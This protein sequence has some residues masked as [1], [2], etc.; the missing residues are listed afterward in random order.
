MR[1]W[2]GF[3]IRKKMLVENLTK[4]RPSKLVLISYDLCVCTP[5]HMCGCTG[6][7]SACWGQSMTSGV[8]PQVS[9]TC[10]VRQSIAVIW[11]LLHTLAWLSPE[12]QRS[13][14]F[15]LTSPGI[16]S[17]WHLAFFFLRGFWW[18]NPSPQ[19][20]YLPCPNSLVLITDHQ[21]QWWLCGV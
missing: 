2:A 12:P 20:S 5:V 7:H 13:A 17:M 3:L 11:S 10:F 21:S 4:S 14:C 9:S 16:R 19:L 8:I 15:H 1:L 6:M 18:S